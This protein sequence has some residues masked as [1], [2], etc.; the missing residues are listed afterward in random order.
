MVIVKGYKFKLKTNVNS[1]QKLAQTAGC[2]RYVYNC[3]L[4]QRIESYKSEGN[5]PNYYKQAVQLPEKK[6]ELQW[7]NNCPSQALQHSLKDLEQAYKNFFRRVKQ[8]ETPGFPRFKKREQKNSFRL[9]QGVK[10]D[11][12]KVFLPKIG[13][14]RFHKS[15][16][17]NGKLKNT[18]IIQD[19]DGWYVSFQTEQKKADPVHPS[20]TTVGIDMGVKYFA[21]LSNGINIEPLNIFRKLQFQLAKEQRR[22]SKKQKKSANWRKQK[23]RVA[24]IHKRIRDSRNDFLH[25]E[26]TQICK[27]HAVVVLENLKV[28]NMSKS[29]KGTVECPGKSVR[30]KSGLNR[31]ILDQGWYTFRKMIEYKQS[32]YGGRVILVDPKNTSRRCPKCGC[33]SKENR[34]T[35]DTFSCINCNYKTNADF[36]A[37]MNILAAG[38]AVLACGETTLVDSVKQESPVL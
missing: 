17:I 9:P 37:S 10:V 23:T 11:E 28:S 25:K 5:S 21:F 29:A 32:W 3:F 33:V 35:Q 31:S 2:C 14:I 4:S 1:N 38:L 13:W 16:E 24:K 22:L 18:T 6:R 30:A 8:K 27:N 34:K 15:Q 26:S 36:N 7:L 12:S 20:K 19:T